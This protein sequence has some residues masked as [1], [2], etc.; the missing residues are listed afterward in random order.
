MTLP[1][2]IHL[3]LAEKVSRMPYQKGGKAGSSRP[4]EDVFLYLK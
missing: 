1:P 4:S 3:K 2:V